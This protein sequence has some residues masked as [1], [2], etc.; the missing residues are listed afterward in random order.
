M[1]SD[2]RMRIGF[3]GTGQMGEPMV[4]RLLADGWPVLA[5]ARRAEVRARL[6]AA[7]ADL[8]D[9]VGAV[10][11]GSDILVVCMF[12]DAQVREIALGPDGA[13][14]RLGDGA[15]LVNHT[16]VTLGVVRDL[17]DVLGEDR[18]VD[19]PVS[20]TAAEIAQGRLRVLVGGNPETIEQVTPAVRSYGDTILPTGGTGSATL[21]KLVNNLLF[22]AHAQVAEDALRLAGELGVDQAKLLDALAVCSGGSNAL[23]YSQVS[24]ASGGNR[25]GAVPYI[26]KDLASCRTAAEELGVSLGFL[27]QVATSGPLPFT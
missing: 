12:D 14:S 6:T 26:R 11:A 4:H 3:V 9:T 10:A 16:T 20:G 24:V 23:R 17:V 5:F 27:E 8:G 13:L 21:V 19:A 1:T 25:N 15:V 2:E 22:A 18:V 7:G